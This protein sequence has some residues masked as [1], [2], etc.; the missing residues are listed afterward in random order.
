MTK[1]EAIEWRDIWV[2]G[3]NDDSRPRLLLVG[4]SITRSCFAQVEMELKGIFFCA[5]LTPG[6]GQEMKA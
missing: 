1:R 2:T 4:D 6:V 3:A 5:R